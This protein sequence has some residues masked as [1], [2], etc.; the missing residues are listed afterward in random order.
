M[1]W[2]IFG[3]FFFFF[4]FSTDFISTFFPTTLQPVKY[5]G[6][7]IV[8]EIAVII[9]KQVNMTE[10]SFNLVQLQTMSGEIL[11]SEAKGKFKDSH[12]SSS[13][14]EFL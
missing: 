3:S 14:N 9:N 5:F 8:V 2:K 10:A 6:V 12:R 11:R 1:T 7:R 13:S 4:H